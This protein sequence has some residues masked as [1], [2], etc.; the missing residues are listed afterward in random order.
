MRSMVVASAG[1]AVLLLAWAGPLPRLVPGSFA[2]HMSL[3]MAVVG[4]AVPILALGLAPALLRRGH[5]PPPLVLP[6]AASLADLVVVWL[7]HAPALHHASRMVSLI[8][9]LEQAS[10]AAVALLI[11]LVALT[12]PHLA[13]AL[14]LFFTSMHM[15][16]LGALLALA[17]RPIYDGHGDGNWLGLDALADQQVG[18][19]VMLAIGGIIYLGG[20]LALAARVLNRPKSA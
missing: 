9:V 16:L 1:A 8:L 11:W 18:G 15:T 19:V 14:T 20:G 5:M 2:A 17:P 13:G 3:H 10:F 12:G 7:W 6:I 4:I